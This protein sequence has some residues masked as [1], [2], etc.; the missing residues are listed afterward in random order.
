MDFA[1]F[2]VLKAVEWHKNKPHSTFQTRVIV[3]QS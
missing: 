2:Y 3:Q 1:D